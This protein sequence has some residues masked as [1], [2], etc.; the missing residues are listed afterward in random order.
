MCFQWNEYES[1]DS[2]LWQKFLV[3]CLR[4]FDKYKYH[5]CSSIIHRMTA[6][7]S[8]FSTETDDDNKT[9]CWFE[10]YFVFGTFHKSQFSNRQSINTMQLHFHFLNTIKRK[11]LLDFSLKIKFLSCWFNF[12]ILFFT[13][14][15]FPASLIQ[16][17]LILATCVCVFVASI[18][19]YD[20]NCFF[21]FS[22]EVCNFWID[23]GKKEVCFKIRLA[24]LL[25][26]KHIR[27]RIAHGEM[28][29]R[30]PQSRRTHA[31]FICVLATYCEQA[32]FFSPFHFPKKKMISYIF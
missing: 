27:Y 25:Q 18:D 4:A 12:G 32:F 2:S 9:W 22:V 7:F 8:F 24:W 17:A 11:C 5:F 14:A 13:L 23:R 30:N 10:V 31:E 15:A 6:I 21:F 28:R 3:K 20:Y 29:S 19:R 1:L 16:R 26:N